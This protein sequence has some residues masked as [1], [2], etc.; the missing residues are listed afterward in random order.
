MCRVLAHA[1]KSQSKLLRGLSQALVGVGRT[2]LSRDA[3]T[4]GPPHPT[5]QRL[6]QQPACPLHPPQ[7]Q[8][9][10]SEEPR[11][12]QE[13][14]VSLTP[15]AQPSGTRA[16]PGKPD[17]SPGVSHFPEPQSPQTRM[18]PLSQ[19]LRDACVRAPGQAWPGWGRTTLIRPQPRAQSP[20]WLGQAGLS[21]DWP[22]VGRETCGPQTC[23]RDRVNLG[24]K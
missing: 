4:S 23:P 16:F 7:L 21:G 14:C 1:R 9:P 18:S 20:E 22:G 5:G 15:R 13:G 24:P 6:S 17:G 3:H 11:D 19:P 8:H 12:G 2:P 10:Q